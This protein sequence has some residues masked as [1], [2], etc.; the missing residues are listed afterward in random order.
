MVATRAGG[1]LVALL[2]E[3]DR[4]G[5]GRA[6]PDVEEQADEEDEDAAQKVREPRFR[7][8][9]LAHERLLGI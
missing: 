9:G 1:P 7:L 8:G 6:V 4:V 3:H 2:I 5:F